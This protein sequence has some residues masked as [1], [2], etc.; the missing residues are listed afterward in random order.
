MNSIIL[1]LSN[2]SKP[3]STS[4]PDPRGFDPETFTPEITLLR[5]KLCLDRSEDYYLRNYLANLYSW[6]DIWQE[7]VGRRQESFD[8]TDLPRPGVRSDGCELLASESG[9]AVFEE[10]QLIQR[11]PVPLDWSLR[12]QSDTSGIFR[13]ELSGQQ[14]T[15][16][17]VASTEVLRVSWP[18][19][20]PFSGP[21][22]TL[23]PW[24]PGTRFDFHVEPAMF[25]WPVV[26]DRIK[27]DRTL[28]LMLAKAN[29]V[30]EYQSATNPR[31]K[32]AIATALL[33]RNHP[34]F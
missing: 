3:F 31:L 27:D 34:R 33:A 12:W 16:R 6:P 4:L 9:V 5:Q 29:L 11:L 7:L 24:R 15:T 30:D 28:D 26:V 21:L 19:W 14:D 17:V 32:A 8:P 1:C 13:N 22:R 23:M 18:T 20:A 10:F 25:P 2:R